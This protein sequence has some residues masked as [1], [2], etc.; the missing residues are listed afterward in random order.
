MANSLYIMPFRANNESRIITRTVLR[1]QTGFAIVLASRI[2]RGAIESINLRAARV[3]IVINKLD[4]RNDGIFT[5]NWM[6][7]FSVCRRA[8]GVTCGTITEDFTLTFFD[9]LPSQN[10]FKVRALL[11][12]L[13][14]AH[15][16]QILSIFQGEGKTSG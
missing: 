14:I 15:R 6:S 3:C 1:P 8:L 4:L 16:I 11:S 5:P 2:Q 12:H 13:A 9:Y 7:K 10:A